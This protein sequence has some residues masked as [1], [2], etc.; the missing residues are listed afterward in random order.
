[1]TASGPIPGPVGMSASAPLL[2]R[3]QTSVASLKLGPIGAL[4]FFDRPF[5]FAAEIEQALIWQGFSC[6]FRTLE[7]CWTP[8]PRD[9]ADASARSSRAPP[10]SIASRFQH[11]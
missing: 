1:M 9:F 5:L 8:S 4:N 10:A 7:K 11:S 3:K 2:G 6:I